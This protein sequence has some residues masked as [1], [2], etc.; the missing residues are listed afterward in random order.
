MGLTGSLIYGAS[1]GVVGMFFASITAVCAQLAGSSR[2]AVGLSFAI[3]I[4]CY[5]LR[6]VT[7]WIPPF[8]WL[9]QV[10]PYSDSNW[11]PVAGLLIVSIV[12]FVLAVML[13]GKR[14]IG[15]GLIPSR[16]GRAHACVF[17]TYT[18][19]ACLAIT[20]D[21]IH[22]VVHRHVGTRVVVWFRSW[23]FGCIFSGQ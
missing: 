3:M 13:Q 4:A 9:T 18:D 21:D 2:G 17:F 10:Q 11:L 23:R 12:L 15:S 14:D 1:L 7:E 19:W 22:I 8:G 6:S 20:K 16:N 5:L